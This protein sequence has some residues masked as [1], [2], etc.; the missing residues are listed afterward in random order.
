MTRIRSR[1]VKTLALL[2]L[3]AGVPALAQNPQQP[4]TREAQAL[5]SL[6]PLIESVKTAVGKAQL[7]LAGSAVA[8]DAVFPFTVALEQIIRAGATAVIQPGGSVKDAEVIACAD[9][10]GMAMVVTGVRHFRH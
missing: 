3:L 8:S 7:P 10:A 4:A 1:L 5:P 9:A 6:A 2:P